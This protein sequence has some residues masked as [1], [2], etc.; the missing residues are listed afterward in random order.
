MIRK[1]TMTHVG[2]GRQARLDRALLERD[3]DIVC[4]ALMAGFTAVVVVAAVCRTEGASLSRDDEIAAIMLAW[5]TDSR[6]AWA[7]L[8]RAHLGFPGFYAASPPALRVPMLV[9]GDALF[10]G[11]FLVLAWYG[12]QVI[13][14]LYGDTLVSIPWVLASFT[15]SVIP[16]GCAI[17]RASTSSSA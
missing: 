9:I 10:V 14:L 8:R 5:L 7:T 13:V 12:W 11:F 17:R 15:Q 6:A 4:V 1:M 3:L 2:S 16:V